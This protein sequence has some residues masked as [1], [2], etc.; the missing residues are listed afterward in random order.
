MRGGIGYVPAP[1][2]GRRGG[3]S[4]SAGCGMRRPPA[5]SRSLA[6]GVSKHTFDRLGNALYHAVVKKAAEGM[7]RAA[8]FHEAEDDAQ[9]HKYGSERRS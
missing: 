3:A 1:G 4:A 8:E 5:Q 7:N 6:G 2:R 9:D